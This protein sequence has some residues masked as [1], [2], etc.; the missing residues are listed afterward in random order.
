MRSR[1]Q[2]ASTP[3]TP[4]GGEAFTCVGRWRRGRA[5]AGRLAAVGPRRADGR[6]PHGC[7]VVLVQRG[8]VLEERPVTFTPGAKGV[9]RA[10]ACNHL[11]DPYPGNPE[12]Q[13]P[14]VVAAQVLDVLRLLLDL[15][16]LNE[17]SRGTSEAG[18][19][20]KRWTTPLC[21]AAIPPSAARAQQRG[22]VQTHDASFKCA[23]LS[24]VT[25]E[26]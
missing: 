11:G 23:A 14:G 16:M 18:H 24:N 1:R 21:R 5:G 15:R 17:Q 8:A 10:A 4:R 7:L 12:V 22:G 20:H 2:H 26:G 13:G 25:G 9:E 6:L 19:A 3:A